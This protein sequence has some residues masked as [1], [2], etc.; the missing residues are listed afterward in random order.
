MI[1]LLFFFSV[2]E[3]KTKYMDKIDWKLIKSSKEH[4]VQVYNNACESGDFDTVKVLLEKKRVKVFNNIIYEI[5]NKETIFHTVCRKG[6]VEILGLLI[7]HKNIKNLNVEWKYFLS[8]I[9]D[10]SI[11]HN[12]TKVVKFLLEQE[13]PVIDP[14]CYLGLLYTALANDSFESFE[15]LLAVNDTEINYCIFEF[16]G[17][18]ITTPLKRICERNLDVKYLKALFKREDL[19]FQSYRN[20][21]AIFDVIANGNMEMLCEFLKRKDFDVNLYYGYPYNPLY[22]SIICDKYEIFK[23]LL[24]DPRIDITKRFDGSSIFNYAIAHENINMIQD[25][26]KLKKGDKRGHINS[27]TPLVSL[28]GNDTIIKVVLASR[29]HK[30][31]E[32]VKT[33]IVSELIKRYL[34]NKDDVHEECR[35][36][37]GYNLDDSAELFCLIK[38]IKAGYFINKD[39]NRFFNIAL[40]LPEEILINL[41][42]LRYKVKNKHL[43]NDHLKKTLTNMLSEIDN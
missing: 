35:I 41:T 31:L 22:F 10:F 7:K 40:V 38:L 18:D 36:E 13:Y 21:Y 32:I 6:H 14:H 5:D 23:A 43:S 27:F 25:L 4:A 24:N 15:I 28:S 2:L 11:Q 20:R 9:L 29:R 26:L 16:E 19:D 37:L 12:S 1:F 34:L 8:H 3:P 30:E 39:N 17:Y 33:M 42:N